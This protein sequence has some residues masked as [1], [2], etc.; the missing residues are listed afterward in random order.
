V[1]DARGGIV[2][3][4]PIGNAGP[5]DFMLDTGASSSIVSDDLARQIGAPIVARSEV[6][7]SAGTELRDVMRLDAVSMAGARVESVLAPVVPSARLAALGQHVRG[8]LGQDFLSAFN[9]TLDDRHHHLTWHVDDAVCGEP[10]A[11]RLS[12]PTGVS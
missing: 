11:V 2:V 5:F 1:I 10:S 9:Y 7:T 4:V 8:V 6:V 3:S 12:P